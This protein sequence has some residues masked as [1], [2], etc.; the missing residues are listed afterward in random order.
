MSA[1]EMQIATTAK[2][3]PKGT[4]KASLLGFNF[5]NRI[6]D[7]QTPQY[8]IKEDAAAIAAT[9]KNVPV[10]ASVHVNAA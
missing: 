7:A 3:G 8:K 2:T 9:H 6:K 4:R 10:T 1:I 5:R